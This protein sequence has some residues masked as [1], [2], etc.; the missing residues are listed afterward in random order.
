MTKSLLSSFVTGTR[1]LLVAQLIAC[2]GAVALAGWTL[3]VTN[4]V[5]RERNRLQERVIQLE[6]AMAASG[7]IP[8][9]S[10]AVVATS[11][12]GDAAYPGS[13]ANAREPGADTGTS[14]SASAATGAGRQ[15]IGNVINSLLGPAPPLRVVVLHV[16]ADADFAAAEK[17]A[18]ELQSG[19]VHALINVMT[20]SDQRPSGYAYFDGRQSRAAADIVARFHD[21]ARQQQVA[22]WSA[23]LRGTALPA[24]DEYTADRL[25]I[26]LPPLPPPPPPP[27]I[28]TPA[29]TIA[30]PQP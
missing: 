10:T 19:D 3:G 4:Q 2:V 26:V 12:Q 29:A 13:L 14:D 16:R 8:P 21:L 6:E 1:A 22:Q 24:R 28:E 17:I 20:A 11:T 15:N 7:V 9:A 25:D 27:V 23:Q 18:R 30:P 5:L